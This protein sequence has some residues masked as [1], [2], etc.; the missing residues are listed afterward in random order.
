M[1]ATENAIEEKAA[2]TH[3]PYG[4]H[5]PKQQ[6]TEIRNAGRHE[7]HPQ[8]TKIGRELEKVQ[9]LHTKAEKAHNSLDSSASLKQRVAGI[10]TLLDAHRTEDAAA[11]LDQAIERW[12]ENPKLRELRFDLAEL[13]Q[14]A[15]QMETA[16]EALRVAAEASY[17]TEQA[18]LRCKDTVEPREAARVCLEWLERLERMADRGVKVC[19]FQEAGLGHLTGKGDSYCRET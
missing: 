2:K 17:A 19:S 9:K 15:E 16:I 5:P 6:R 4:H 13:R 1:A 8:E 14:Q 7:R 12:P 10:E 18:E 11:P 3:G